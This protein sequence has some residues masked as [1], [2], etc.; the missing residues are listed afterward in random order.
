MAGAEHPA[1][2]TRPDEDETL[3]ELLEAAKRDVA[4][5]HGLDDRHAYRLVGG[6]V[7]E[8]HADAKLM[9]RELGVADPTERPRDEVG[10]YTGETD[11]NRLIRAAS[12]R[13]M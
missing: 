6:S 10:R 3:A 12:G 7:S 4:R 5:A 9:A 13:P 11:M 8:L 1:G 2:A